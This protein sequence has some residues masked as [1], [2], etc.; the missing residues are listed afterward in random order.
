[1]PS[2]GS[3]A[4]LAGSVAPY[5]SFQ[6]LGPTGVGK[7]ELTRALADFL[8]DSEHM[9]RIDRANSWRSIRGAADRRAA[10]IRGLRRRGAT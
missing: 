4:G 7:T 1:M 8:F 9:I 2:G 5:G 6:F 3:R 10:G